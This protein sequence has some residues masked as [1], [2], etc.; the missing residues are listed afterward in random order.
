MNASE[1]AKAKDFLREIIDRD[2]AEGR[3]DHVHT[4]FAPE[5]NA[6]IH[7]GSAFSISLTYGVAEEHG[8]KYNLRFDDTNPTKEKTEYIDGIKE[9]IRWLGYDW[10]DREFYASDY[11]GQLYEWAKALIRQ[12]KAYVCDLSEDEIK[13]YRGTNVFDA[14][15]R[16]ETPPGTD[17]PYRDRSV[18]ENLDLFER[19]RAGE[20]PDGSRTLRAKIDMAH[21]NLIMRDPVM[22]RIMHTGHH[23][24]GGEWC[25]YP[26]Y[27]WAHGQS[28]SIEGVTHSI[29]A[30]EFKHHRPL[31]DWFLDQLGVHHPR[32]I[33]YPRINIT[34]TVLSKRFLVPLVEGGHVHGWDDPRL[35]TLRGLRRRGYPPEVIRDFSSRIPITES[36]LESTIDFQFLEYCARE[37]LNRTAP[38]V[39]AVLRPVKV[40][41]TNYPEG[42]E[43]RLAAVNNPEDASAGTREVPFSRELYIE[44]EDFME[45]PV[46]KFY[47][48]SPGREVRLRY[49]YFIT[50]TEV[51]KSPDGEIREIR[52]TYDPA[53]R[54]GDAPD[55][56]KVKSTLHWVSARHAVRA[57]VRLYDKLFSAQNPRDVGEGEDWLGNLN[58]DSL[59]VLADSRVEP[60]LA[61]REPGYR[62][63]FER[64][65]YFCVDPDSEPGRLV[66]NRTVSLKD[67]WKRIQARQGQ[68]PRGAAEPDRSSGAPRQRSV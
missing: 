28:D 30:M 57:E 43:E 33:E 50:C 22:Y 52:C 60:S 6:Y 35:P 15:G 16:R 18:E 54:G 51:L 24:T 53:T 20:F 38:R 46:K 44:R 12:G 14:E 62:C 39:M 11:F 17:S 37:Y 66:F 21:D 61:D 2:L 1:E 56:R 27:D 55:G 25:I 32:Q 26:T 3:C 7:I 49:A 4:R 64:Q 10:E 9:D 23:R 40:V 5:P 19:M 34:H 41:I 48:L 31:Y 65:G 47:R 29:C 42:R 8:G 67:T 63:Q 36:K 45:V 59:V 13:E 58:P 68:G